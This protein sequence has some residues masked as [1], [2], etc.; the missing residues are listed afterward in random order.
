MTKR[1]WD[2]GEPRCSGCSSTAR[3]STTPDGTGE[4]IVDDSFLLLFNAHHED[5][6]FTLPPR[7]LRRAVDARAAHG[8]AAGDGAEGPVAAGGTVTVQTRSLVAAAPRSA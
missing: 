5:V 2:D 6:E 8:R 7:A 1:D 3:R 4:R